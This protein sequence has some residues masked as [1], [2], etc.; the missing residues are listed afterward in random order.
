MVLA[1]AATAGVR[2]TWRSGYRYSKAGV[3]TVDLVPLA[4]CQRALPGLGRIDR[5]KGAALMSAIDECNRSFGRGT[6]VPGKAG[7]IPARRE[8]STKFEIRLPRY[9]TRLTEL[10]VGRA[11]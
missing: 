8:W 6:V 3:I 10:P 7:V 11:N 1:K 9:T 2:C 4:G 5:E